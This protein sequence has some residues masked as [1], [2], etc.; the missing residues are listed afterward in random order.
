MRTMRTFIGFDMGETLVDFNLAGEWYNSLKSEVIP[1]MFK[2]LGEFSNGKLIKDISLVEFTEIVYP[3]IA[4]HKLTEK[5]IPM[6]ERIIE[7]LNLIGVPPTI[8]YI[9][10]QL[11]AFYEIIET[12]VELYPD[13]LSTLSELKKQNY[14]LGLFSDTPWQCPGKLMERLLKKNNIRKFFSFT[15]YSGDIKM[16]KPNPIVFETLVE[17]ASE[18][19]D[20][21]VYI[22]D[23]DRDIIACHNF[24][25]PSIHINRDGKILD[26]DCPKP[27]Y[28]IKKLGELLDIFPIHK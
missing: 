10:S 18:T 21:M 20:N 12:K 23:R 22:G 5:N 27:H 8:E 16:R 6:T 25:I 15:L 1:R 7:Y 14:K 4:K 3:T 19:K 24:G 11:D 13:V 2:K 26:E 17:M 9:N 28:T